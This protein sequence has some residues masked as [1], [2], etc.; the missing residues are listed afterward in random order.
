MLMNVLSGLL[1]IRMPHAP[2]PLGRTL[3]AAMR[4]TLE[5][6]GLALVGALHMSEP[7]YTLKFSDI[8]WLHDYC[9][10]ISLYAFY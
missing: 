5:M 1:V 3:V 6:E 9:I 10:H 4:D 7:Y 8:L 2:T